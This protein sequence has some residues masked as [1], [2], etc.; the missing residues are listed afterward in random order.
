MNPEHL[1]LGTQ[2]ENMADMARKKRAHK[3]PSVHSEDH[4]RSKLTKDIARA[5][6]TDPRPAWAI[7]AEHG[8][9]KSLI[10]GIKSGTHWKYA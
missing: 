10:H 8:V 6:R 9:S 4:P 3:G 2:A 7:A 1:F 5:I